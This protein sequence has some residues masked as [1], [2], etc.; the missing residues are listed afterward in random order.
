MNPQIWVKQYFIQDLVNILVWGVNL[1]VFLAELRHKFQWFLT[2]FFVSFRKD[3]WWIL[4]Y[5]LCELFNHFSFIEICSL[6]LIEKWSFLPL[7]NK[8]KFQI[9]E[10][11]LNKLKMRKMT[12]GFLD[13]FNTFVGICIDCVSLSVS[14]C[15]K[16][17]NKLL[18]PIEI[19]L[20]RL[21]FLEQLYIQISH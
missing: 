5:F 9:V 4:L 8:D 2:Y 12:K 18:K 6:R 14:Q 17:D 1:L 16:L 19:Q 11:L 20:L 3:K 13:D 15:T 21:S 7:F 10:P